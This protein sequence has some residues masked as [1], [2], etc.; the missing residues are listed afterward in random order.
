VYHFGEVIISAEEEIDN[1]RIIASGSCKLLFGGIRTAPMNPNDNPKNKTVLE[2]HFH[3]GIADYSCKETSIRDS[4]LTNS[5]KK[6]KK[7]NE[8]WKNS[9]R[10]FNFDKLQINKDT[11]QYLEHVPLETLTRGHFFGG[12]SLL[13]KEDFAKDE[14]ELKKKTILMGPARLSVVVDSAKVEVYE[15]NKSKFEFIPEFLGKILKN[16]LK[17]A[18]EFD[19]L[20]IEKEI[21]NYETWIDK[22]EKELKEFSRVTG[23]DLC[24]FF[25]HFFAYFY[26]DIFC[27]IFT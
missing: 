1:F 2:A 8:T 14:E 16:G 19:D 25:N 9:K 3:T 5:D 13:C 21:K 26:S 12:R 15:L 22:R 27:L 11:L 7:F 10:F 18:K 20:D 23:V 4:K 17:E 24:L 6:Q